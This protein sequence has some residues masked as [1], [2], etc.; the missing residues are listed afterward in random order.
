MVDTTLLL[1]SLLMA[2]TLL[3]GSLMA[4]TLLLLR[5]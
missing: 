4:A 2:A 1:G 3:L 5:C